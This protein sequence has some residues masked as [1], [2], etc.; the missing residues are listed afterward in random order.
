M[1]LLLDSSGAVSTST[2]LIKANEG[3]A[4]GN[5]DTNSSQANSSAGSAKVGNLSV[6]A[7]AG[8]IAG[9]L[10]VAAASYIAWD[11]WVSRG[12]RSRGSH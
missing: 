11:K 10:L 8:I 7:L 5:K 2:S 9:V 1:L 12:Q 6:Y 4:S 3:F